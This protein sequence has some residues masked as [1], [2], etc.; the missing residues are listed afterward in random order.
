MDVAP[1]IA[2]RLRGEIVPV[3]VAVPVPPDLVHPVLKIDLK[4]FACFTTTENARIRPKIDL[5]RIILLAN[6]TP[7]H[8]IVSMVANVYHHTVREMV[9]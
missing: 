7:L 4:V 8:S 5:L 3:E 9:S 6:S 1:E 2:H